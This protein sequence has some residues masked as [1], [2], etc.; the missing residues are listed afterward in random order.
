[1]IN[2]VKE[3]TGFVSENVWIKEKICRMLLRESVLQI[4]YRHC[5]AHKK[6]RPLQIVVMIGTCK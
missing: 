3:R 1:M 4:F 5:F 2:V 6:T